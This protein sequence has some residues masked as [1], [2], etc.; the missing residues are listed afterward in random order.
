M[1]SF[2][3]SFQG[4]LS[5]TLSLA[6]LGGMTSALSHAN[7]QIIG[8]GNHAPTTITTA[9]NGAAVIDIVR[10]N[11]QGLS[12]N[13]YDKYNVDTAGAVLNN[14]LNDGKSVLAGELKANPNL[15]PNQAAKVILNEVV[16]RNPSL[17]LGQQEVF[18][19]AADYVL[20]NPNGIT[21]DGC[22]F[23]NIPRASMVVGS[24]EIEQGK[25][26]NLRT[27]AQ[28]NNNSLTIKE[29]GI[30]G[31]DVLDLVAPKITASGKIQAK[32]EINSYTGRNT[33][34]YESKKVTNRHNK[35][36]GLDGY[37][38]GG[39]QA[40]RINIVSTGAGNGVNLSGDIQTA[41]GDG[42]NV[43]ATDV[44][45]FVAAD[46]KGNVKAIG[47]DVNLDGKL[48]EQTKHRERDG[49]YSAYYGASKKR[50]EQESQQWKKTEIQ[51]DNVVL[52]AKNSVNANAAAIQAKSLQIVGRKVDL[53]TQKIKD[54]DTEIDHNWKY[55]WEYNQT[56]VKHNEKQEGNRFRADDVSIRATA[57][58]LN[59]SG[60]LIEG[61][62]KLLLKADKGSVLTHGS[63]EKQTSV[64]SGNKRNHTAALETGSWNITSEKEHLHKTELA[65]NGKIGISAAKNVELSGT[66]LNG[67]DDILLH[68]NGKVIIGS[69]QINNNKVV[70]D[71]QTYW[72]GIGGGY[73]KDNN[74]SDKLQI[75]SEINAKGIVVVSGDQG[76]QVTGSHIV[77]AKGGY[78]Q[79]SQGAIRVDNATD[80]SHNII[81]QRN[82]TV[83]NITKD[84]QSINETSESAKQ[85]ELVSNAK[86]ALIANQNIDVIG[87]VVKVAEQLN[88]TAVGNINI[89]GAQ[90]N[91]DRQSK[92]TELKGTAY[93][94]QDGDKQYR[95]GVGLEMNS[96]AE[97][98]SETNHVASLVQSGSLKIDSKNDV[99]IK[100]SKLKTGNGD[101][102][103]NAENIHITAQQNTTVVNSES[104][105]AGFG[106]YAGGGM[107][108]V[109]VGLE[110]GFNKTNVEKESTTALESATEI[111]GNLQLNAKNRLQ[112]EGGR[113]QVAGSLTETANTIQRQA[114]SNGEK[115]TTTTVTFNHDVG[116]GI[117][118]SGITRPIEKAVN[119]LADG[120]PVSA[121]SS[122]G[123]VGAPNA[124]VTM[125]FGGGKKVENLDSSQAKVTQIEASS[126][127]ATADRIHDQAT[128][129]QAT[130]GAITLNAQEYANVAA[131]N[132]KNVTVSEDK[133]EASLSV[134]T[135]TGKDVTI[136]AKGKGGHSDSREYSSEA[137]IGGFNAVDNIDI[138]AAKGIV[139]EGNK[140]HSDNGGF[141]LNSNGD[142][143]LVQANNVKESSANGFN[144]DLSVSAGMSKSSKSGS[145]G[146]GGGANNQDAQSITATAGEIAAKNIN[147]KGKNVLLQ[148][149]SG[150]T[151]NL[152]IEADE[153]AVIT[154][155]QGSSR[156]QGLDWSVGIGGGGGSTSGDKPAQ[157]GSLKLNVGVKKT[158]QAAINYQATDL[159]ADNI[160]IG[161]NGK[162]DKAIH[163]AGSNLSGDNVDLKAKNGSIVIES[164]T[165]R[166]HKDNRN[167]S[168][169]GNGNLKK[170][171]GEDKTTQDGTATLS[172]ALDNKEKAE[173]INS[174]VKGKTVALTSGGNLTVAGANVKGERVD[175]NI[176]GNLTVES[177]K[178]SEQSLTFNLD[179]N[180]TNAQN[181]GAL[182][183][184]MKAVPST[185]KTDAVKD[186]VTGAVNSAAENAG[187][188]KHNPVTGKT[189]KPSSLTVSGSLVQQDEVVNVSG[190]HGD[191]LNV[192]V[193]DHVQLN[194]ANLTGNNRPN[195]ESASVGVSNIEGHHNRYQGN[196]IISNNIP[197]LIQEGVK[198][199]KDGKFPLINGS[200]SQK[201]NT[202]VAEIKEI[203]KR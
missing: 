175:A 148:G 73:D 109:T 192:K 11:P 182:T 131:E 112:Y 101:A 80:F 161:A 99:N 76:V 72:G 121:F 30:S 50:N 151:G 197:L 68:A 191:E 49:N 69:Q 140:I 87:S 67:S 9:T 102:T 171:S 138:N 10:P 79:A 153:S 166:E 147:L 111:A 104:R 27:A 188:A 41:T 134:A 144:L 118:L 117:E 146:L 43:N 66:N 98:R 119:N 181:N 19:I 173:Q 33:V 91:L 24:A 187:F 154:A 203:G 133:G 103:I 86:F 163:I 172:I 22:G 157:N 25:I 37:Y 46:I 44:I 96:T 186:K 16:S 116:T 21:C 59:I 60:S 137:V 71:N 85:S 53:T 155:A 139:L 113:H 174:Q 169:G 158:D 167:V 84:S 74:H 14:S 90:Q 55:S 62:D 97:A 199:L 18:G 106:V 107:D 88:L 164:L 13:T 145:G 114:A 93:A 202:A 156:E 65:S 176:G 100:G 58:D 130:E 42:L 128:R 82:G 94:K 141:T 178:S 159:K 2:K 185:E 32:Q 124:G 183:S 170:V 162:S 15:T 8:G 149:M 135:S 36:A 5:C 179:L 29:K 57:D 20:A 3:L 132:R 77:A 196:V 51:G 54:K 152:T 189:A 4:K 34:D 35:E 89:A 56:K 12:H 201:S 31:S 126:V 195:V 110:S 136:T 17:L 115:S 70:R 28:G 47:Q 168:L 160:Q 123:G 23:I 120:S 127:N 142:V 39:M 26:K 108:R 45:N 194:G 95:A 6:L 177:R 52:A 63:V 122:I 61:H 75:A 150:K 38:V 105:T 7:Q 78:A 1:R 180:A 48:V 198:D 83:F 190:I 165:N 200:I 40:G 81:D 92:T 129:Y 125:K 143:K 64:D 184:V 193:K